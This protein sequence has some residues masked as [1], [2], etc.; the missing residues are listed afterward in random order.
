M[1]SNL[2]VNGPPAQPLL[3]TLDRAMA[4][5]EGHPLRWP[6]GSHQMRGI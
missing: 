4:R 5:T 3:T 6:C 2:Q 1:A